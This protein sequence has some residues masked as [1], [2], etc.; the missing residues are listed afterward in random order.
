MKLQFPG[1]G[2]AAAHLDREE[3]LISRSQFKVTMFYMG[4]NPTLEQLSGLMNYLEGVE[5][6]PEIITQD[7]MN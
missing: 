4:S 6:K 3:R 1:E 2:A 5:L 7:E